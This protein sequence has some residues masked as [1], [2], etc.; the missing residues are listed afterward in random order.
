M[1]TKE[2][3]AKELQLGDIVREG[4]DGRCLRVVHLQ[5]VFIEGTDEISLESGYGNDNGG[6]F[7]IPL[8]PEILEKNGFEV[9]NRLST[10]QGCGYI[11]IV[12]NRDKY[13]FI[14]IIKDNCDKSSDIKIYCELYV[15]EMQHA[16]RL[17]K[18]NELADNFE[19]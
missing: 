10:F 14:H 4:K 11:I 16:L 15:H 3:H 17:C 1:K 2:L 5:D 6:V 18:L 8:T 13:K 12:A 19:V 7:P 9:S